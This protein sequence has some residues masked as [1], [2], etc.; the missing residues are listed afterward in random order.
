MPIII[1][2]QVILHS[3]TFDCHSLSP[4]HLH[5]N[6]IKLLGWL[7]TF[8]VIVLY[9]AVFSSWNILFLQS[10]LQIDSQCVLIDEEGKFQEPLSHCL[11]ITSP[12]VDLKKRFPE[13][14]CMWLIKAMLP[15]E[16]S[17]TEGRTGTEKRRKPMVHPTS[18]APAWSSHGLLFWGEE[19]G[20]FKFPKLSVTVTGRVGW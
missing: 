12:E 10:A 5:S 15:G 11:K 7:F 6:H 3:P 20:A 4:V 9:Y 16:I 13:L 14:E 8:M 18:M 17:K 1:W 19:A 2:S